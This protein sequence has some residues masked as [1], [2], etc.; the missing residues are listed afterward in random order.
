M[1]VM[2]AKAGMDPLEFRL[3]NLADKRMIRVVNAAAGK[4]G[5]KPAKSPSGRG[6]GMVCLDYLGTYVAAMAEIKVDKNSGSIQVVRLVHAQDMG[7]VINPEGARMQ[8]EGGITMGLGYCLSEEIHFNGGEIKNQNFDDYTITHFSWVPSI[9]TVL[10]D[11]PEIPPS[12]GGE[13][14]IVGM[15]ALIANALYDATGVRLNRLPLT[16][17]RVKAKL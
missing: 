2:A 8:I 4:F 7:P 11:N 16:P 15:G 3:K 10:V 17:E 5:W 13:P 9:E 14:P 1:D 6:F 12:G